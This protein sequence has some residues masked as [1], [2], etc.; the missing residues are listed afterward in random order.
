MLKGEREHYATERGRMLAAQ[1]MKYTETDR[2]T[3]TCA[4][5]VALK[6]RLA[7]FH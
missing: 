1:K 7:G 4:W 5:P 3:A 6:A 2:Q